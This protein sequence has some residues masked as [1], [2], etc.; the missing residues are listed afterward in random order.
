MEALT[1]KDAMFGGTFP[2]Q[3][4]DDEIRW[5]DRDRGTSWVDVYNRDTA[6][7]REYFYNAPTTLSCQRV[8]RGPL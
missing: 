4:T 3:V 5:T 6:Q 2:I 1:V 7:L 8:A